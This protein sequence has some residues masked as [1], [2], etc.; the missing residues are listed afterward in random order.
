[1]LHFCFAW[2]FTFVGSTFSC[3]WLRRLSFWMFGILFMVFH[4]YGLEWSDL[5]AL[6]ACSQFVLDVEILLLQSIDVGARSISHLYGMPRRKTGRYS[7]WAMHGTWGE[8]FCE[9]PSSTEICIPKSLA[10]EIPSDTCWPHKD[11]ELHSI[12]HKIGASPCFC[13][14]NP[15]R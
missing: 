2:F 9:K 1:M 8:N 10:N 4:D 5:V 12:Q 11:M 6:K 15:Y 7:A 13:K 3:L 14:A